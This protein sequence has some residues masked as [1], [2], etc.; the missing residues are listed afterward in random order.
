MAARLAQKAP[1]QK[2][3]G[4][5]ECE[6][7]GCFACGIDVSLDLR[8]DLIDPL[9]RLLLAKARPGGHD[10]GGV[11]AVRGFESAAIAKTLRKKA[12][13]LAAASVRGVSVGVLRGRIA[14]QKGV[15]IFPPSGRW[16]GRRS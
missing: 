13:Y 2:R 5:P 3:C 1:R 16:I 8:D 7:S 10:L 15:D 14:S 6:G 11:I 12:D 9:F 4:D